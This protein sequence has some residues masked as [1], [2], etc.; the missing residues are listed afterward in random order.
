MAVTRR[1]APFDRSISLFLDQAMSREVRAKFAA[2]AARTILAEAQDRYQAAL[3]RVPDHRTFVDGNENARLES[4]N[5]DGGHIVFRFQ[6]IEQ[7]VLWIH[8]QLVANSPVRK[9]DYKKSHTFYIDG[10]EADLDKPI[11]A[12]AT[13][14]VFLSNVPYARKIE[15]GLSKQ[16]PDGVYQGVAV[17][18]ARRFGNLAR[19]SFGFRSPLLSYVAGGAN[20]VERAALRNQP[21]RR[22]AMRMERETRI[23]A[24]IIRL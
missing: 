4:V 17:L 19:I 24:I 10:Q 6:L 8:E 14:L 2:G 9:G 11:P 15:R 21:A 16:S 20:R 7:A 13:E 3:G 23:P 12:D 1:V 18:A 5:P 22:S